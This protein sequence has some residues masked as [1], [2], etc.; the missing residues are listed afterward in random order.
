MFLLAT[1]KC[2]A[3]AG[4]AGAQSHTLCRLIRRVS[5]LFSQGMAPMWVG[6]FQRG[7][8]LWDELVVIQKGSKPERWSPYINLS[9][10]WQ[11][12]KEHLSLFWCELGWIIFGRKSRKGYVMESLVLQ[13]L[14]MPNKF[15]SNVC[16]SSLHGSTVSIGKVP[17]VWV[18]K[19]K[20]THC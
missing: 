15:P 11:D 17:C 14:S 18:T 3:M 10:L 16:V 9:R 4:L 19:P 6:G 5:E 12:S 8:V 20:G 13:I 2:W 1:P 7:G